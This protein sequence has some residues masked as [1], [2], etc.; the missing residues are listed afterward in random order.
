M[1]LCAI[2]ESTLLLEASACAVRFAERESCLHLLVDAGVVLRVVLVC[3]AHIAAEHHLRGN[4]SGEVTD[5][6]PLC[7]VGVDGFWCPSFEDQRPI[8]VVVELALV[9]SVAPSSNEA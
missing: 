3:E 9:G 4:I 5:S 1:D 6:L 2:Q 7:M 8:V